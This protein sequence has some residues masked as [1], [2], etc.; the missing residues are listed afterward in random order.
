MS[1]IVAITMPRWGLTM[2]E[3]LLTQWMIDIGA[4]VSPGQEIVEIESTKL[5]GVVEATQ[6]G[7]M[8]RHVVSVGQTVPTGTLIGVVAGVDVSE[9]EI[10]NFVGEFVIPDLDEQGADSSAA[11]SVEVDGARIAYQRA[12]TGDVVLLVHGFGGDA[13]SWAMVMD[14]L[15]SD[16]DVIAVDLPG[17]GGSS[18]RVAGGGLADQAAFLDAFLDALDVSR[19]HL[20]GHSMGGGVCIALAARSPG[21]VA[22]LTLLAPMGLGREINSAYLADFVAAK[23]SRDVKQALGSL[24]ADEAFLSR[25]LVDE[26]LKYKRLDGVDDALATISAALLDGG[27]QRVLFDDVGAPGCRVTLLAGEEDRIIPPAHVGG[28][29][30]RLLPGVGH[31]PQVEATA[32][33]VEAI[34]DSI[35]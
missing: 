2:E 4:E 17:H 6:A 29:G 32:Q 15:S 13:T 9:E 11:Q 14:Q 8:R 16:H 1:G 28:R 27:D 34:R 22:S 5:A 19:A 10:D 33:V 23:K 7:V 30:G 35:G 3:G 21:R 18:K 24:F 12:G 20:I 26:V 31:M 25:S